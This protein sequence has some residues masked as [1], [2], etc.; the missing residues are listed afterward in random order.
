MPDRYYEYTS[1]PGRLIEY[2]VVPHH[3]PHYF[4]DGIQSV[5]ITH[6]SDSFEHGQYSFPSD[7]VVEKNY[8]NTSGTISLK[9]YSNSLYVL[10]GM[11]GMNPSTSFLL[12]PAHFEPVE[13]CVNVLNQDRQRV[14]RSSWFVD[15]MP[16]YSETET[17][18]D[19]P[20]KEISFAATR[21]IDFEGYQIIHQEWVD[22]KEGDQDFR[23]F[24]PA[25][26]EVADT[27]T[28]RTGRATHE[29][30]P[31]QYLLRVIVGGEVLNDPAQAQVTTTASGSDVYSTLH[32][33]TPIATPGTPVIAFWLADGQYV[34]GRTGIT[35]APVMSDIVPTG[36]WAIGGTG[37]DG[38][39]E[40]Y[41]SEALKNV[42]SLAIDGN[43][44]YANF[45]L[46]ATEF[47]GLGN[48]VAQ[49]SAHPFDIG[50]ANSGIP[51][52]F[53]PP[54]TLISRNKLILSFVGSTGFSSLPS[55]IPVIPGNT[56][57]WNLQYK[58]YSG[59]LALR[60]EENEA[61]TPVHALNIRTSL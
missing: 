44:E 25:L 55:P 14:M 54:G 24:Y 37:W 22:T 9:D 61:I 20:T 33:Y 3:Y 40:V 26:V 5:S 38:T 28:K 46:T 7:I 59:M 53:A 31:I 6:N 17:L 35:I 19:V 32:L 60:G 51:A 50:G 10:R 47:D 58:A 12:D 2:T 56:L 36:D 23:L 48:I 4:F 1:Y 57:V 27:Y 34:I 16:T 15:F 11:T 41:F 8:R 18:D 52:Q 43:N 39:L 29:L 42:E 21:K 30:S 49:G 45:L 13:L